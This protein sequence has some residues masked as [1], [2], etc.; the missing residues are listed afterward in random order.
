LQ[1]NSEKNSEVVRLTLK[2]T[3]VGD[4]RYNLLSKFDLTAE[5][6]HC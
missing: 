3:F 5:M 2:D 6:N 1:N 4:K